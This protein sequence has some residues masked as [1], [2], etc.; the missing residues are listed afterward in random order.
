M[1]RRGELMI[2]VAC[3]FVSLGPNDVISGSLVCRYCLHAA[4]AN[5]VAM[6]RLMIARPLVEAALESWA[7]QMHKELTLFAFAI[8]RFNV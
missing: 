1:R 2:A 8:V 7:V 4:G 3:E 6:E 5:D